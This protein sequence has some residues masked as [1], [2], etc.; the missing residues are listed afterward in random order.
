MCKNECTNLKFGIHLNPILTILIMESLNCLFAGDKSG[1]LIQYSLETDSGRVQKDYGNL[2]IGQIISSAKFKNLAVFGG[3]NGKIILINGAA[4]EVLIP[5]VKVTNIEIKSLEFCHLKN[6]LSK[7]LL[8]IN[9]IN[10][11]NWKYTMLN[12]LLNITDI[13]NK[14]KFKGKWDC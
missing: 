13:A 12:D 10:P 3:N 11:E 14:L 1:R 5:S 8:V 2:G 6:S 9:G 4:K 7:L